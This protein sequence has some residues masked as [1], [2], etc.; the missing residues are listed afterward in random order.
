MVLKESPNRFAGIE[1]IF[2]LCNNKPAP[3][4]ILAGER[5][6]APVFN[7]HHCHGRRRFKVTPHQEQLFEQGHDL[8]RQTPHV[9]LFD[10]EPA[11]RFQDAQ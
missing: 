2:S 1:I 4:A 11:R 8:D 7:D 5:W 10:H 6:H 3:E 9:R